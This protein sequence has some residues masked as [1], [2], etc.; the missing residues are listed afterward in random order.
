VRSVEPRSESLA[1]DLG[2]RPPALAARTTIAAVLLAVAVVAALSWLWQK[3]QSLNPEDHSHQEAALRELRSLDRTIN[4]DVLRARYKLISSYEPVLESYRRVDELE[5]VIATPPRFLD[6]DARQKLT[7]AVRDYRASVTAKERLI[8]R[9]KYRAADLRDLL[10][11]LPGA[12]TALAQAASDSGDRHLAEQVNHLVQLVLLYNLTSDEQY[13][14]VV[15]L[16][17]NLLAASA[18]RSDSIGVR[19][20]VRTLVMNVRRLLKV[21]P[22]VDGLLLRIFNEPIVEHEEQVARLYY[23]DYAAAERAARGYRVVLYLLCLCLVVL[24]GFAVR[25]LQQ[26]AHALAIN[27]EG[28]EERVAERTRELGVV[29]DNVD[30]ALFTVDRAGLLS[31]ERSAALDAWFPQAAPGVPLW[32]LFESIDPQAG[33]WLTIGWEQLGDAILPTEVALG[34]LPQSL[35]SGAT[36]RRYRIDY[37]AVGDAAPPDRVLVVMSDVTEQIDRER[38]E[39]DQQEHLMMFQHVMIDGSDFDEFFGEMDRLVQT[40]LGRRYADRDALIRA[41]HTMKGSAGMYGFQSIVTVCHD[42]E[43]R[44]LD[45]DQDLRED[46]ADHLAEV[47][48]AFASKVRMLAGT[49]AHDRLE[50]THADLLLLRQAIA[51]GKSASDLMQFLRHIER[52]PVERRLG[53]IAEQARRLGQRLGKGEIEVKVDANGLR[54]DSRRWAPFWSAFVHLL[55][56]ALDHG[57]ETP[58]ERRAAG[59]P[60]QGCLSLTAREADET[61][62]IEVADDGRG[63]DWDAV[64]A[65]AVARGLTVQSDEDL[66]SALVR[67]GV[68]TKTEVT[69]LSGRGSGLAACYYACRELGGTMSVVSTRGVGTTF[70]LSIPSDDSRLSRLTSAA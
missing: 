21:K 26:T 45:S 35:S 5:L 18:E 40:I 59:K 34:Q 33:A 9:V 42:L 23:G 20:R 67:G 38:R 7:A 37:R 31:R 70:R 53:R 44:I 48:S 3:T 52:D 62:V 49:Q 68:S 11:Y 28:L 43:T 19:R 4:Q 60:A 56:N 57:L 6:E 41:L 17:V 61:V 30:Q 46:D 65:G 1:S 54:L 58:E 29:L 22:A 39:A 27:N 12:G 32:Q 64:R 10:D 25:R 66:L 16:R 13:A 50:V 8:E 15:G 69:E 47:W 51:A 36:G 55:R 24:V 14:P 63:I 2:R